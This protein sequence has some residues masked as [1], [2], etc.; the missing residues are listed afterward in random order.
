MNLLADAVDP[1][2]MAALPTVIPVAANGEI[3]RAA[4]IV[5]ASADSIS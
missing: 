3:F 1:K 4:L 2:L 5:A